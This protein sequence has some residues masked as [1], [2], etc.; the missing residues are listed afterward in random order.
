MNV[1]IVEYRVI[2]SYDNGCWLVGAKNAKEAEKILKRGNPDYAGMKAYRVWKPKDVENDEKS[3]C[4]GCLPIDLCD[5][6]DCDQILSGKKKR[7]QLVN[8]H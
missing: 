6:K 5:Q 4:A 8:G 2:G 7:I 3:I 1:Y